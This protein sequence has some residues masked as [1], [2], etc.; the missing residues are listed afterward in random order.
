[1]GRLSCFL[2]GS[3]FGGALI[4]NQVY[5]NEA[6]KEQVKRDLLTTKRMQDFVS[7]RSL[8]DEFRRLIRRSSSGSTLRGIIR[9]HIWTSGASTTI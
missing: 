7:E 6:L 5:E 1:M 2:W 8:C 4:L 9:T 3:V